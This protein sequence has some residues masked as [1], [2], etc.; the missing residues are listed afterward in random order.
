MRL[1]RL[2]LKNHRNYAQLDL[3]PGAG[4]NVFI[5]PNGHG[6]TN[7]LEAV[8]MLALSSSPRA[9]RDSELVGPVG[10]ESPFSNPMIRNASRCPADRACNNARSFEANL[11]VPGVGSIWLQFNRVYKRTKGTAHCGQQAGR[12]SG[13]RLQGF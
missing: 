6:K 9:R 2:R 5:G 7:L 3:A 4:V 1:R 11:Y 10:P 13:I 12:T 8:A